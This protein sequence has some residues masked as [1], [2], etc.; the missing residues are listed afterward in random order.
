MYII[1]LIKHKNDQPQR[2]VNSNVGIIL[3]I[4]CSWS[5]QV[6]NVISS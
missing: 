1:N 6:V 3:S 4:L 5:V 2:T